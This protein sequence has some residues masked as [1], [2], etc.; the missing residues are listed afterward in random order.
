VDGSGAFDAGAAAMD[1]S[2]PKTPC[3]NVADCEDDNN[4]TNDGC[5]GGFCQHEAAKGAN[6]AKACDDGNPCTDDLCKELDHL[7][8]YAAK[9]GACDDGN[10]CTEK[11]V[12]ADMACSGTTILCNDDDPCTKDGC[13]PKKGC[14]FTPADGESCDDSDA[15]TQNDACDGGVCTGLAVDCDDKNL[16]TSDSCDSVV[17][18]VNADNN[19]ACDDG[20]PCTQNDQCQNGVCKGQGEGCDDKNPCTVDKCLVSSG[21][22]QHAN[23]AGPCEDG[24]PCTTG[25]SCIGGQCTGAMPKDCD[26]KNPCTKD[27]CNKGVCSHLE[28]VGCCAKNADCDDGIVCTN[29]TCGDDSLCKHVVTCCNV[30]KDCNDGDATCTSDACV[31]GQ[32]VYTPTNAPGCCNPKIYSENFDA[33]KGGWTFSNSAGATQGWQVWG[34]AAKSV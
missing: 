26:D 11:D 23:A 7:C 16:C 1:A 20:E 33:G 32:C 34:N 27:S 2:G 12:C 13:T 30:S 5:V 14:Q 29:D 8:D 15:C 18:C 25:E 9:E 6:E 19:A 21:T 24:Q 28:Q 3:V 17:G 4:C 22:C 31:N 10:P